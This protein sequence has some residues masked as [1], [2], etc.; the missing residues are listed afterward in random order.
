[1]RFDVEVT[2]NENEIDAI[3]DL[4]ENEID[5][6]VDL[7]E[8]ERNASPNF[9]TNVTATGTRDHTELFNRKVENAH[10]ISA[11]TGLQEELDEKLTLSNV[12]TNK[13]IEGLLK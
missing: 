5:S 13:E 11:I 9:E 2:I 8:S 7:N 3:V 1:M 10:P 4:T 12:L 6:I